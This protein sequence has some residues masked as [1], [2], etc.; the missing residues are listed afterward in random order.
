MPPA[1]V[2][3]WSGDDAQA[4]QIGYLTN[5]VR[6]AP[7]RVCARFSVRSCVRDISFSPWYKFV[8][9]RHFLLRHAA[10][11]GGRTPRPSPRSS[12]PV[13]CC[14]EGPHDETDRDLGEELIC[15]FDV[16]SHLSDLFRV[17][18]A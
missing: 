7:V 12:S 14:R 18:I 5:G 1:V 9:F 15:E 17:L 11:G 8:P 6:C 16:R 10:R 3:S 4:P 13:S 2:R